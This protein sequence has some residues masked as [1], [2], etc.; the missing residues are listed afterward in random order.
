MTE[1][2]FVDDNE[3]SHIRYCTGWEEAEELAEQEGWLL[4]GEF[5]YYVD[6]DGNRIYIN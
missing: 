4:L 5:M 2:L 3:Q 1:F 6:E